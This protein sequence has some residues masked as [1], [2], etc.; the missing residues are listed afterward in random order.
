[1]TTHE[2]MAPFDERDFLVGALL[3][4]ADRESRR[5]GEELHDH[6]CQILLGAGFAAKAVAL[7]LPPSSPAVAELDELVRLINSAAEET[8]DIAR[9]LN[10]GGIDSA[11]LVSAL[12]RLVSRPHAGF[13]CRFECTPV[14]RL[15]DPRAARHLYRIAE[16]AISN[17]VRHS[18]GTEIVVRLTA[19]EA[20]IH[21]QIADNGRGFE[22]ELDGHGGLGLAMMKYRA[23]AI[24]AGL[25]F[26]TQDEGGVNVTCSLPKRK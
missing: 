13:V 1:M 9:G 7:N 23:E 18:R 14:V 25:R 10:P 11:G 19:D 5:I 12:Q 6:L 26:D 17:A 3:E 22:D 21:L 2:P 24:H 20:G 15:P 4:S 16:E 8:R